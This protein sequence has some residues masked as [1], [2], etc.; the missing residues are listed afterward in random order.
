MAS[1][2]ARWTG[3]PNRCCSASAS[4]PSSWRRSEAG[5]LTIG[6]NRLARNHQD[7]DD[8]HPLFR[9]RAGTVWS[10]GRPSRSEKN[11]LTA[12]SVAPSED[13]SVVRA[14]SPLCCGERGRGR[15]GNDAKRGAFIL[16]ASARD[17]A[18]RRVRL[19]TI[20]IAVRDRHK[21]RSAAAAV[22]ADAL[23]IFG[24][25]GDLARKMTFRSL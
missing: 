14:A 19:R 23:V 3:K 12:T 18:R 10:V 20:V 8:I 24:I 2:S 6:G 9:S 13:V 5:R 4:M 15:D 16:G 1:H 25:T 22:T 21:E 7:L 17:T 11:A